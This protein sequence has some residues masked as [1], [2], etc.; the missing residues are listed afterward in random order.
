MDLFEFVYQY[1]RVQTI[2]EQLIL[3]NVAFE[4]GM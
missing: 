1:L 4:C 2:T 3:I